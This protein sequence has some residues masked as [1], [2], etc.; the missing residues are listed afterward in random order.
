M[1][2]LDGKLVSGILID[3]LKKEIIDNKM[4]LGFAIIWIGNDTASEI[5][6]KN[7][8]KKCEEV[9]IKTKLYHLDNNVTEDEVL[10]IVKA[11]F[12]LPPPE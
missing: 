7:K 3:N 6:V 1:N 5:Y 10:K 2:I 8:I 12:P 11:E 4:S 9:G